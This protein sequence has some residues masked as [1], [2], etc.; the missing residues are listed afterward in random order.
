MGKVGELWVRGPGWHW[1]RYAIYTERIEAVE[2][3][4]MSASR[5]LGQQ[6]LP[7]G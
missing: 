3:F 5:H 7:V 6:S 1:H 4:G 2:I